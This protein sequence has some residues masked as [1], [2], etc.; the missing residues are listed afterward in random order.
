MTDQHAIDTDT[1]EGAPEF[2]WGAIRIGNAIGRNPNI[3]YKLL[4][5]G[6]LP[7]RKVGKRWVSERKMLQQHV[8]PGSTTSTARLMAVAQNKSAAPTDIGSGAR[9]VDK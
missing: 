1:E 5:E 8:M 7:A 6:K 4:T 3:T 9:K 2:L